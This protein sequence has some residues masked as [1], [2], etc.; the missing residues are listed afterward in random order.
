MYQHYYKLNAEPFRLTPDHKFCFNHKSYAK[1]KAYMQY[2]F[3]RAEGFVMVTG[4]PGTGK[5]TLVND[6]VNTLP[7]SEVTLATLVSTQLEAND[8]LRTSAYSFGL[9]GNVTHKATILQDLAKLLIA[10][11]R[12]GKRALLIIDEAQDLAPSA[13]EELRLLTNFQL[14]NQ[15]LI[16]IF[17]IG[18]ESLVE[19]VRRPGLEQVHQRLI[20]ACHL[21]ALKEEDTRAYIKHRL[22]R[23][24]W[25]GDP[26][27]SDAVFS[28]VFQF[29][30]GVPRRINLICS[31]LLLHG[32]VE[33]RHQLGAEDARIVLQELEQEQLTTEDFCSGI[34]FDITDHFEP[35]DWSILGDDCSNTDDTR[36]SRLN[37]YVS[38]DSNRNRNSAPN[39]QATATARET[40]V[41]QTRDAAHKT[42]R[43]ENVTNSTG[44]IG[45]ENINAENASSVVAE[46]AAETRKQYGEKGLAPVSGA[47]VN[48]NTNAINDTNTPGIPRRLYKYAPWLILIVIMATLGYS[49]LK[50]S[51]KD[52]FTPIGL[53]GEHL[54]TESSSTSPE[55]VPDE[56][57]PLQSLTTDKSGQG[58]IDHPLPEQQPANP[59]LSQA[60]KKNA[61][62]DNLAESAINPE[63]KGNPEAITNGA[64]SSLAAAQRGDRDESA[65]LIANNA[66]PDATV[67]FQFDSFLIE[68]EFKIRLDDIAEKMGRF[69]DMKALVVGYADSV[70]DA[71]YN[72][73][74]SKQR[75]IAVSAYLTRRGVWTE[76]I[77]VEG[78]G[79][80]VSS[81]IAPPAAPGMPPPDQRVVKVF[82]L[83]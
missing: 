7:K 21:E 20:A 5:T 55:M 12:K 40:W 8:L 26:A 25:R 32:S 59:A 48:A 45:E 76:R 30:H 13:L 64:D 33:E 11:Y 62:L 73:R 54:S 56:N 80:P 77:T 49:L 71:A 79:N 75:A 19:L 72:I 50:G 29:S 41:Q 10:N 47:P 15:P 14:N 36:T 2:A 17:L 27:I 53:P 60:E 1:A 9:D 16:Q 23:V 69:E 3:E 70:G 58:G 38:D 4:K 28:L 43:E 68:P 46:T 18:Q 66:A 61:P 63:L 44:D 22:K 37:P 6:L 83:P 67:I 34:D 31:R 74:L 24:G 51:G 65:G 35:E 78:K 42:E 82:L 52:E 57:E 81:P 39:P